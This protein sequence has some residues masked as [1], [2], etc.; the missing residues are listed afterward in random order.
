MKQFFKFFTASCLGT[1]AALAL[2]ILIFSGIGGIMASQS[3]DI[4]SNC[5]LELDLSKAI[6]EKSNNV[7]R[8]QYDFDTEEYPGLRTIKR[9]L[10]HAATDSKIKGIVLRTQSTQIGQVTLHEIV[11]SLESF[12]ES[13]K[14]I[15]AYEDFYT[16]SAYLLATTADSIFLNPNGMIDLKGFGTLI[17]FFKPLMDKL[18]VKF[19]I[20]YAG[21]FKS[22]TEPY[23]RTSMSEPNKQQTK[24]FLGEM[25]D[26]FGAV[27]QR[28]RNISA[29]DLNNIVSNYKGQNGKSCLE[30]KLVDE[31][32]YHNDFS[33]F[34]KDKVDIKKSKKLKFIELEDYI[35]K[36]ALSSGTSKNKIAIIN[37]EG[38]ITYGTNA[39]GETDNQRFLKVFDKIKRSKDI[40]AVVMRVNSPGGSALTSDILWNEIEELKADSIPVITSMGNY[41]ASGG[42]Y[43]ACNSDTIIAAPSTLT[44]SIGVFSMIPN[45]KKLMTEK[46]GIAFDTVKTHDLALATSLVYDPSSRENTIMQNSTDNLYAQFLQR[47]A[48]GRGM[49]VEEVDAVAQGRV[50]T[51]KKA[52]ELGLV[53]ELGDLDDA[54]AMAARMADLDEYRVVEYPTIKENPFKDIM[55]A[56]EDSSASL[57]HKVWGT[58]KTRALYKTAKELE[59]LMQMEGPMARMPY[60]IQVD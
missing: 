52:I 28:N 48:D 16:Q 49:T 10:A 20:Y 46:V 13:G 37:A 15:Y 36:I 26:E 18:G 9:T 5:I 58:T 19:D 34:L 60:M 17:P 38:T 35:N 42:Y 47:V 41:A 29:A 27:I 43:I 1:I 50:W 33:A 55:K 12:K 24:Q 14:F 21:K 22:A 7:T 31:L 44:G 51:G 59:S 39:S 45:F 23:R 40:K 30:N 32:L 6:P 11:Q 54:I 4:S 3:G 8:E 56:F 2:L 25:F 53:D 57:Q